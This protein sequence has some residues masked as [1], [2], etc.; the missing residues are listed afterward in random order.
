MLTAKI[1]PGKFLKYEMQ[2]PEIQKSLEKKMLFKKKSPLCGFLV[3]TFVFICKY[4][5]LSMCIVYLHTY[6][7]GK[8]FRLFTENEIKKSEKSIQN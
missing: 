3:T 6:L 2:M 8:K 1:L 5:F 7:L 4:S